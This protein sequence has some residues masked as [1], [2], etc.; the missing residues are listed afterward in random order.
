[1][2]TCQRW[3]FQVPFMFTCAAIHHRMS[4]NFAFK[5]WYIYIYIHNI[6]SKMLLLKHPINKKT[7]TRM[8]IWNAITHIPINFRKRS[9]WQLQVYILR[10]STCKIRL[11]V[12][13]H[14]WNADIHVSINFKEKSDNSD[15]FKHHTQRSQFIIHTHK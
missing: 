12:F 2:F 14:I 3:P 15:N 8:D 1:M 7:L 6:V 5:R 4:N 9:N 13:M 11:L 10:H